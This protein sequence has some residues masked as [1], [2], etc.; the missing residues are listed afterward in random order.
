MFILNIFIVYIRLIRNNNS[1][2]SKLLLWQSQRPRYA[3]PVNLNFGPSN[4]QLKKTAFETQS[5]VPSKVYKMCSLMCAFPIIYHFES[6]PLLFSCLKNKLEKIHIGT[7]DFSML[8]YVITIIFKSLKTNDLLQYEIHNVISFF[9]VYNK[10]EIN[11]E[12]G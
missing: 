10:Y 6:K 11:I 5:L 8:K 2:N 4:Y 9:E 1:C 3:S 7:L 12:V